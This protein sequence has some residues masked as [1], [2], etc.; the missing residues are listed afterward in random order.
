MARLLQMSEAA[1][2]GIHALAYLAGGTS[3]QPATVSQIAR[4]LSVSEAHL[5]KVLQ[6]LAKYDL[7]DSARGAKGGFTL[8]READRVDLLEIVEILDGPLDPE[9]CL[10]GKPV[11]EPG[12]CVFGEVLGRLHQ[13]VRGVLRGTTLSQFALR[14]SLRGG[15]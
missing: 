9:E 2:L 4:A 15:Q 10:L 14:A 8:A 11:C 1:N 7:V 13:E 3:A 12:C 6:R 5:G